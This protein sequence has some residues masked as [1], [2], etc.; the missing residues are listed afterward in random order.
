MSSINFI[1]H[2]LEGADQEDNTSALSGSTLA[3]PTQVIARDYVDADPQHRTAK[4]LV[5]PGSAVFDDLVPA[6]EQ[7]AE[8][9][10][11]DLK[12]GTKRKSLVRVVKKVGVL[13]VRKMGVPKTWTK[14]CST[15]RPTTIP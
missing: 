2:L 8:V 12:L 3:D 4:I 9:F 15:A 6:I 7:A 10:A 13:A 1:P 5:R 11:Q 14:V